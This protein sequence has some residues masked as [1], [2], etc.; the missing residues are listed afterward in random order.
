MLFRSLLAVIGFFCL[1]SFAQVDPSVE[2]GL[3]P[4]AGFNGSDFAQV[5]LNNGNLHIEIPIVS[6]TER[7]RTFTWNY[8]YDTPIWTANWYLEPTSQNPYAGLYAVTG[9]PNEGAGW[10]LLG[11][12]DYSI[13]MLSRTLT[14]C[15]SNIYSGWE[16]SDPHGTI[17]AFPNSIYW[18]CGTPSILTGSFVDPAMDGSGMVLDLTNEYATG[19]GR[20]VVKLKDGTQFTDAPE[21]TGLSL[22]DPNGN[23][24]GTVSGDFLGR[25][26]VKTVQG[27]STIFTTPLGVKTSP[28]PQYMLYQF[29]DSNGNLQTF[30]VDN[31]VI[32]VMDNV[33]SSFI[34]GAQTCE[35]MGPSVILAPAKLTLPNGQ[36]Y[37]FSFNDNTPCQ[38][39]SIAL[40]TGG[41][42]SFTYNPVYWTLRGTTNDRIPPTHTGRQAVSTRTVNTGA[43][44]YEWTYSGIGG[45]PVTVSDPANT[46]IHTFSIPF[47]GDYLSPNYVETKVQYFAP[48][49]TSN[50]LRTITTAYTG[51]PFGTNDFVNIRPISVTTTLDNGMESQTQTDYETFAIPPINAYSIST[52]L[53]PTETREY[54]FGPS[55]PGGLLRKTDYTYLHNNST[56]GP[57][58]QNLNIV[59]RVASTT[60]YNASGAKIAYTT[61]EYDNYTQGITS[62]GVIQHNSSFN[63]S[64]L[65]RGNL[66]AT[67]R[68]RN[69]DGATLTTRRQY[70]D[71]GNVL[72]M[73]DP[74]GK[75]TKFDF[76]DSWANATCA[77]SG[78]TKAYV[79]KIT[80]A[81]SQT[82]THQYDSC[83]GALA[84]TTDPNLQTTNFSYDL[85]GRRLATTYA[86]G[87]QTSNSYNDALPVSATITKKISSSQNL[88][89]TMTGDGLGRVIQSQ[90]TSDPQGAV[91]TAIAYDAFGRKSTVYNPTRCNPPTANCGESTWGYT[92]YAYDG[93][94]R[95]VQITKPD[96]SILQSSYTG[97]STTVAD[98]AGKKRKT[99]SDGLGRLTQVFEDPAGFNYETDY[100]YDALD[101]LTSV[102]QSGSRQ[103]TFA[104]DS[105]KELTS[106]VNPESGAAAYAYD[107]DGNV[108]TKIDARST[109]TTYSYDQLNRLLSKVYSDS[110]PSATYAYDGNTPSGCTTGVSSYGL[111]IG[112]RTAMCDAAGF[113]AWSY[114]DVSNTGWQTTDKRSTNSVTK[115]TVSQNNLAD[116]LASLTYPSGRTITYAFSG[117]GL[118]ISASDIA[119]GISYASNGNYFPAG[120]LSLL[121]LGSSINLTNIFN[122][123]QQAC[124]IY[125]ATGTSLSSSSLCTSS[126]STG[127]IIDLKYGMALGTAD[128]GN[129]LSITNNRFP[130]RSQSFSYDSFNRIQSATTSATYATDPTDCWGEAYVYDNQASGGGPWGNLTNINVASTSYNS[131]TQENLSVVANTQNRITSNGY[132]SAGNMTAN[133]ASSY[134]YNAENQLT[135]AAGVT[136][137][138]DGDD[139]RLSKSNGKIYWYGGGGN[140][141]TETDSSGN[142]LDEYILF[143]GKRIARRDSSG[144]IVYYVGDQLGSSRV[145][146]NSSGMILDDSDFYPF[147]GERIIT[148]SSGNTYKFTGKERDSESNLDNFGARYG[149]STMGRFM[150][151]DP[152]RIMKQKFT[153]PQQWNMYAYVR[154]N[155]LRLVDD[156]GKWPTDI[157]DQ[158]IDKAFPGLS[159]SQRAVLKSASRA[160][161]GIFNGGQS[162]RNAYKHSMKSP[163]ENPSIAKQ[164]TR[165]FIK[166]E[167]H[168]AQVDQK[169]TPTSTSDINDKSLYMFGNAA[170]T[171]T[172]G[173]SSEHVDAQGNPLPWNPW[174][175]PAVLAHRNGESTITPEQMDDAVAAVQQAFQD[176]YGQAAAQQAFTALPVPCKTLDENKKC[177]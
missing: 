23:L 53:N 83:T 24:A 89:S 90:V 61:S 139:K 94:N 118:P 6:V 62:S 49:T 106:A 58:Y 48:G 157:H 31:Q 163:T 74:L 143:G 68:W 40:P 9:G 39:S 47:S 101:D 18:T 102:T 107:N 121:K 10:R 25:Q 144:N 91:S 92:T 97:N 44:S 30:R 20:T 54:D 70:D 52:R 177:P 113:E 105:L 45:G 115:T 103:R 167:E 134:V 159:P 135:S 137:E 161:D 84:S 11:P 158:I 169:T 155:P 14:S 120:E 133:G 73:V 93:I 116:S 174:D 99:V 35:G 131:C 168:L 32:D 78:Q 29:S 127:N 79:T 88:V 109:K 150:S 8:V 13:I 46:E 57:T 114:I 60:V 125:A 164:D 15:L 141:I 153:D 7:G 104:Y 27:P 66:T 50:P 146:T 142:A 76:T 95:P 19:N 38:L 5:N 140:A 3:P 108:A 117:T 75:Q 64:Y 162:E 175:L 67:Q 33:C 147:G 1:A 71:A 41:T 151:P 123:R 4:F 98:E 170:H 172:D 160:M 56:N 42:I 85:M 26:I 43:T 152:T 63:T 51:D 112:R 130:N 149:A 132:D 119:N 2:T 28:V 69:T 129:V 96:G 87:A 156:N 165:D 22:Q 136:Y 173:T 110:T 16:V 82:T 86:D 166:T 128:N 37:V 171:V 122:S 154:N 81:A 126:A 176:T 124:W 100:V 12:F 17:H 80:N 65:T 77:T 138:Y 21:T 72:S 145:V 55:A 36:T 148:A 59:D 111:A 34:H